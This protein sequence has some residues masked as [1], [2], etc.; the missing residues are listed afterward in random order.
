M[1]PKEIPHEI[2]FCNAKTR[3]G[4]PCRNHPLKGKTRCKL[5]GGMSTG[6]KTPEGKERQRL[7]ILKDGQYTREAQEKRKMFTDFHKACM[8]LIM[9]MS[10]IEN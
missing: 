7:A 6:A 3:D 9:Q 4:T 5:H 1:K 10:V 8:A 2:L